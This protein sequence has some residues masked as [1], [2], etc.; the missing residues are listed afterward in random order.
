MRE[1]RFYTCSRC[2]RTEW[3]GRPEARHSGDAVGDLVSSSVA[4]VFR[5]LGASVAI[6]CNVPDCPLK[7][8]IR[9]D[10]GRRLKVFG[11]VVAIIFGVIVL[12]AMSQGH[13]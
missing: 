6:G 3:V 10:V 9:Q 8:E 7:R 5:G 2:G 12:W 11:I 4:G 13:H 1:G